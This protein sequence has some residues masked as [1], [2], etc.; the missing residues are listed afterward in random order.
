[1]IISTYYKKALQNGMALL[2]LAVAGIAD[3]SIPLKKQRI[4]PSLF[5]YY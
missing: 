3:I 4:L 1:M 5:P 2:I